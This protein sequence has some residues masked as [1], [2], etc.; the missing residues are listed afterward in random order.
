MNRWNEKRREADL[1]S[2]EDKLFHLIC[3]A[4]DEVRK[5]VELRFAEFN[6]DAVNPILF[7]TFPV[8]VSA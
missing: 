3:A 5:A 2:V 6:R 7:S 4:S 8:E 1:R